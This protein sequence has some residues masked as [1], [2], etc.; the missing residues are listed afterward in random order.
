MSIL[1]PLDIYPEFKTVLCD[2]IPSQLREYNQFIVWKLENA[3]DKQKPT[4]IPYSPK[5]FKKTGCN[6]KYRDTWGHY[7]QAVAAFKTGK[8]T[9]ISFALTEKDPFVAIDLDHCVSKSGQLSAFADSTLALINSYTEYSPSGTGLHIL[10]SGEKPGNN[11]KKILSEGDIE[12]YEHSRF[13]TLTGHWY[14]EL[15]VIK[16]ANDALSQLYFQIWPVKED[17]D[18]KKSY[19]QIAP[20]Q[21]DDSELIEKIHQSKNGHKFDALMAGDTSSY[22]NADNEGRTEADLALCMILAFWTQKDA[23]RMERIFRSS[24]LMRKKWDRSCGDMSYGDKTIQKAISCTKEVY[25]PKNIISIN[26]SR[27][28]NYEYDDTEERALPEKPLFDA[29]NVP[30]PDPGALYRINPING[31]LIFHGAGTDSGGVIALSPIWIHAIAKNIFNEYSLVVKFFDYNKKEVTVCFPTYML[32]ER[33]GAIGRLIRNL[34][35]PLISGKERKVNSYLDRMA[36]RCKN[37]GWIAEKIGWF[38][39]TNPPCFVLP[40]NILGNHSG[41]EVFYQSNLQQE[42]MSFSQIG[43]LEQWKKHVA[44]SAKNNPLLMFG[45]LCGFGAALTK[46]VG[47]ESGGF[48]FYGTTSCGK[49]AVAQGAASVWGNASDPQVFSEKTSIRRWKGTVSGLEGYAQLHN[50]IVLCLDEIGNIKPEDLGDTI[51]L[52]TSGIPKARSQIEGGIRKQ[53]TWHTMLV[54][55]GELT[56]YQIMKLAGESEKGGQRHR[57]PDIPCDTTDKGVV[58]DPVYDTKNKRGDF[59]TKYKF[60]CGKYFGTAGPNFINYLLDLINKNGIIEFSEKIMKLVESIDQ[61]LQK[62]INLPSEGKRLIRRLAIISAAGCYAANAGIISK[63]DGYILKTVMTVRNLWIKESEGYLSENERALDDFKHNVLTNMN[64]FEDITN[65]DSRLPSKIYGY[66]NSDYIMVLVKSMEDLCG[67]HS[68]RNI[69]RE[70]NKRNKITL[71]ESV[72]G[73]HKIS[74]R[75]SVPHKKERPRCYFIYRDFFD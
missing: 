6:E 53:S 50:D 2:Y 59:I 8:F 29:N 1:N 16:K 18:N 17:P 56:V 63:D 11:C 57:L 46:L 54:S 24:G 20:L 47:G 75:L 68:S 67:I 36:Y 39:G 9:G 64:Y 25:S 14:S 41:L 72:K 71:G 26:E 60:F 7:E 42:A 73:K 27:K 44:D 15:E 58:E 45:I 66:I 69:L 43:S 40:D 32:S 49:T 62:D 37:T 22:A 28:E 31:Q 35:M 52:L 65:K 12:I 70:L 51:Y 23:I 34:G 10:L 33:V 21:M 74:K 38:E 4:K 48:H 3:P 55:T 19:K 61:R 30:W 13:I 5:T